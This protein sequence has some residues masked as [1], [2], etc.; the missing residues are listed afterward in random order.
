MWSSGPTAT[1]R[2]EHSSLTHT[3]T[4][5]LN[6]ATYTIESSSVRHCG[7]LSSVLFWQCVW[8]KALQWPGEERNFPVSRGEEKQR[9]GLYLKQGQREETQREKS[10][11][12][13]S[14]T[15]CGRRRKPWKQT[16]LFEFWR[17]NP[18]K[19]IFEFI[20]KLWFI[21]EWK[22]TVGCQ[23]WTKNWV[24]CIMITTSKDCTLFMITINLWIANT[25]RRLQYKA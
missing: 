17:C 25:K 11:E 1:I 12:K 2:G 6:P 20:A 16:S 23:V 14:L 10:Q 13:P 3:H 19:Q 18:E 5:S 4:T 24:N 8:K 22:I 7:F 21:T 15:C 9:T